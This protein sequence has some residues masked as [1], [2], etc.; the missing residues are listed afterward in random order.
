MSEKSVLQV[1]EPINIP[2]VTESV[3]EELHQQILS[4]DLPPGTKISEADVARALGVSRQPVRDAFFRLSQ[5]GFLL[6]RPQRA[7]VISK[8]SEAAVLRAKFI[9][10]ALELACWNVAM[11][12]MTE[13]QAAGLED[14]LK[15]QKSAI[16]AGDQ[17]RFHLLDDDFHRS[18]CHIAGH[19][20][21]WGLIK[22]QKAH[23]D[24]VRFLSLTKGAARQ[25]YD[26]HVAL[27]DVMRARRRSRL[28]PLLNE[29]LG[30]IATILVTMRAEKP[31]YFQE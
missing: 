15:Q 4:L 27:L 1:L 7:T 20:Y 12:V 30:R 8:I 31:A 13:E 19:E 11:E 26:D 24:R 3:F 17:K 16:R 23:M 2:S 6:I 10:I 22:E 21:V 18:I 29:H 14:I 28:E 9:R 25:A 5:L